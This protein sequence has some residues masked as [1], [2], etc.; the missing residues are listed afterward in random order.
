M[1][2]ARLSL[3]SN[4]LV[5]V[6]CG[7]YV[8][9]GSPVP[10]GAA[11]TRCLGNGRG[12]RRRPSHEESG[13]LEKHDKKP[14]TWPPIASVWSTPAAPPEKEK[15]LWRVR[16][17]ASGHGIGGVVMGPSLFWLKWQIDSSC[18]RAITSMEAASSSS[19]LQ[20]AV[21]A[22]YID[23]LAFSRGEDEV[24]HRASG[25]HTKGYGG[26]AGRV[27]PRR[28]NAM[29]DRLASEAA[30]SHLSGRRDDGGHGWVC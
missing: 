13:D 15:A 25:P 14:S 7:P 16:G 10:R 17:R 22:Q 2:G 18:A 30:R 5:G 24:H 28:S 29:H 3:P 11:S 1:V 27:E 20:L 21:A 8:L 19:L 12:R 26:G 4:R 23:G 6:Q 9:S